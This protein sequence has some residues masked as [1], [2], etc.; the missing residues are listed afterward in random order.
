MAHR[1][2]FWVVVRILYEPFVQPRPGKPPGSLVIPGGTAIARSHM[3]PSIRQGHV[4]CPNDRR[5]E[6]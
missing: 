6:P 1:D 4:S 3:G 5:L 2:C